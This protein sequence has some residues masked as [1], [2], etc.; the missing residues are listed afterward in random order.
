MGV[1]FEWNNKKATS[2]LNKHKVSFEEA[3]TIFGDPL[4]VIFDDEIHSD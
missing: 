2:N 1:R 4:A 3:I